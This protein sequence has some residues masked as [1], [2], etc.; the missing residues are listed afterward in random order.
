MRLVHNSQK[1]KMTG[2]GIALVTIVIVGAQTMTMISALSA[3]AR[4]VPA[5]EAFTYVGTKATSTITTAKVATVDLGFDRFVDLLLPSNS[6]QL[7]SSSSSSSSRSIR[8]GSKVQTDGGGGDVLWPAG[9]ALA[10]LIANSPALVE[11]RNVLELGCGLGLV[12]A[13][14]CKYG[15]PYHVAMSDCNKD[16]LG[17]AYTSSTQLQRSRSSVSRCQMTWNDPTTWPAQNYDLLL[18]SDIL[19]DKSNILSIVNVMKHYLC[20]GDP[21]RDESNQ[22]RAILVDPVNQSNRDAF[23]FAAR[24]AGLFVETQEFRSPSLDSLTDWDGHPNSELVLL[25]VSPYVMMS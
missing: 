9:L 1:F 19:Y 10:R 5:P 21:P 11:D 22:K 24:K 20:N 8:R 15:R 25:N 14:A 3:G 18:A 6:R 2:V 13:A 7:A 17:L 12:S 23:C 16:A 4:G